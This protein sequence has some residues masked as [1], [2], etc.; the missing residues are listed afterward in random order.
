MGHPSMRPARLGTS[1]P[2]L[3]SKKCMPIKAKDS[4][5]PTIRAIL[6]SMCVHIG[7]IHESSRNLSDFRWEGEFCRLAHLPTLHISFFF[8]CN[9]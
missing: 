1:H 8:F 6:S 4:C 7:R 2:S 3:D 5:H 9:K